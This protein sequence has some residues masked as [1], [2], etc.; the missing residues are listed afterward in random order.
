MLLKYDGKQYGAPKDSVIP[1]LPFG[2]WSLTCSNSTFAGRFQSLNFIQGR[3]IVSFI[4]AEDAIITL[5]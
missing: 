5:A 1:Y 4:D 2:E 3:L